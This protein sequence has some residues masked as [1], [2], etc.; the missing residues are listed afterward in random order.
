MSTLACVEGV[1]DTVGVDGAGAPSA[2]CVDGVAA[3]FG[4]SS[5]TGNGDA[6]AVGVA[7]L[8]CAGEPAGL[9]KLERKGG[10]AGV[11]TRSDV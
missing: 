1:A 10:E 6:V 11:E 7:G 2:C 9:D 4:A 5:A 3:V 8:G